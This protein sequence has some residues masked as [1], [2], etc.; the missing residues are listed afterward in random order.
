[1]NRVTAKCRTP[2]NDRAKTAASKADAEMTSVSGRVA[3]IHAQEKLCGDMLRPRWLVGR[4]LA[5]GEKHLALPLAKHRPQ[6]RQYVLRTRLVPT[7][8]RSIGT[9]R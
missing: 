3:T 4:L 8:A 1:M 9:K 7:F 5:G 2:K 6:W